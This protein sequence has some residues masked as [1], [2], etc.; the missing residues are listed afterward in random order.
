MNITIILTFLVGAVLCNAELV[1]SHV[2][3]ILKDPWKIRS[4]IIWNTTNLR[5]EWYRSVT[6]HIAINGIPVQVYNHLSF[7][8]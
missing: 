7:L 5:L 2:L 6:K 4:L 8:Y 3:S 1:P